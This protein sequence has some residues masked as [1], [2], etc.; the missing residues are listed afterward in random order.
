MKT[1]IY[2]RFKWLLL[3]C[4]LLLSVNMMA[5]GTDYYYKVTATASPTGEGKVY[6]SDKQERPASDKYADDGISTA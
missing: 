3:C 6:V 2:L 4:F 1:K 5:N